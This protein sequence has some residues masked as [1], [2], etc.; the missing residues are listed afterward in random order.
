MA[1]SIS[2]STV[3]V[4]TAQGGSE[5]VSVKAN[6]NWETT[7]SDSWI[8]VSNTSGTGDE[9]LVVTVAKNDTY[10]NRSGSVTFSQVDGGITRVLNISQEALDP[11]ANFVLINDNSA[12]DNVSVAYVFAE[13][14]NPSKDKNNIAAHSLDKDLDTQWAGEGVPGEI[15]YDLGGSFDLGLVDFV[16]TGGKTYE[17]QIWVSTTGMQETDFINAFPNEG[18]ESG[19]LMSN[20]TQD[21]KAFV[22]PTVI[23]NVKYVKLI[24]YGQPS[25]PS[26][27]NTIKEI[28]FY[29]RDSSLSVENYSLQ[30]MLVYPV[31]TKS[32]LHITNNKYEV[33]SVAI[34]NLEGKVLVSKNT[35][36]K[37]LVISLD[38]TGLASGMYLVKMS[39]SKNQYFSKI[40]TI[41]H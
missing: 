38:T 40:I 12:T 4:F 5:E 26:D 2:L 16:S 32:V 14:I 8:T 28:E 39:N 13:E 34:I 41:Q 9:T 20:D 7:I 36:T 6:V 27:W 35:T 15:I 11:R 31:P 3:G 33:T 37:D 30:E 1:D 29:K 24:G 22:L 21:F 23:E 25:R 10:I 18:N 19:N 17:F